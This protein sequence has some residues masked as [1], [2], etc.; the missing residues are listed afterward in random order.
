MSIFGER[1]REREREGGGEAKANQY[2]TREELVLGEGGE[3]AVLL[4]RGCWIRGVVG[5]STT[6]NELNWTSWSTGFVVF[7][8]A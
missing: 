4:M 7:S 8:H 3:R 2:T 1:E 6:P 5:A